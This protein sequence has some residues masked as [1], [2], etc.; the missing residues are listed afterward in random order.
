MKTTYKSFLSKVDTDFLIGTT[1]FPMR[2]MLF[3]PSKDVGRLPHCHNC[4]EIL[5]MDK[6]GVSMVINGSETS[7]REN[8]V[9]VLNSL[10]IHSFGGDGARIL[11]LQIRSTFSTQYGLANDKWVP[12]GDEER[13]LPREGSDA[14]LI[15]GQM[16]YILSMLL[17]IF[18]EAE[19]HRVL[20]E[21]GAIHEKLPVWVS[22]EMSTSCLK[23]ISCMQRSKQKISGA[24]NPAG[25]YRDALFGRRWESLSNYVKEHYNETIPIRQVAESLGLTENYFC[26]YFKKVTAMTFV[27]YLNL[28][29]CE[30]AEELL[31]HSELSILEVAAKVGFE[32]AG[33]F[34]R[35]YRQLMGKTPR[36]TRAGK[37]EKD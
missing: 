17:E 22:M 13:V 12:F 1:L 15:A 33:Y 20:I 24:D 18:P 23:I 36:E 32:D 30:R 10:D 31:Q 27:K 26:R 25:M 21:T 3:D 2:F 35:L 4:L 28:Y 6:K 11:C 19:L 29:R 9:V 7:V 8:D 16:R 14:Q 5:L 34:S 37:F